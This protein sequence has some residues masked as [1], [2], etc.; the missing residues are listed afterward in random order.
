MGNDLGSNDL[1]TDLLA[2]LALEAEREIQPY[3]NVIKATSMF[4][5]SKVLQAFRDLQVSDFCFNGST[6]YGYG[7]VSREILDKLYARIFGGEAAIVRTQYV[8]GTH[9]IFKTVFA[10]LRPG[11]ELVFAT[12]TPYDT[13]KRAFGELGR[14]NIGYKEVPL[15]PDGLPDLAAITEAV[16]EKTTAVMIQRSRGYQNRQSLS[17][18]KIGEI[19]A[20]VKACK[21]DIICIV[22]NCYGE[23]VEEMEPPQA[24]VDL[25]VGSLI[26]NPGGGIAPAGGYVVGRENLVEAAAESLTAPGLGSDMGASLSD[27]RILYQGLFLAPHV[28]AE[29]LKGAVFAAWLYAKLGFEVNPHYTESRSDIVQAIRMDTPERLK[30]FCRCIQTQSPVD[31]MAVPEPALLPGYSD[32]VIMAAGTFVQG[33]SIELGADAPLRPPYWVYL[34]GGLTYEYTKLILL[35]VTRGLWEGG[36][37]PVAEE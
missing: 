9:A 19:V 33:S 22:D 7:D 27:P 25:T 29:A 32:P 34:Q 13:L 1:G 4:N 36:Y 28:V 18:A 3:I 16:T 15:L 26:K 23:F 6:G 31:S 17:V 35:E 30:E 2:G 24:G 12:G 10:V 20:A 21:S 5:H 8:S 14:W 11:D 37:L